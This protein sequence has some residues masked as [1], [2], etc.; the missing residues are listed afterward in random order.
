M[1][2]FEN[3][4][5]EVREIEQEIEAQRHLI[6]LGLDWNDNQARSVRWHGKQFDLMGRVRHMYRLL[7]HTGLQT[8]GQAR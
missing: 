6:A 7:A 1:A 4:A 2:G 8:H 5:E 3:Y